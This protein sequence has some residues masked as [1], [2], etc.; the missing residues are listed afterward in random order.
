MVIEKRR[1]QNLIMLIE[2]YSINGN[3]IQYVLNNGWRREDDKE[4]VN[5]ARNPAEQGQK[6]VEEEGAAETSVNTDSQRRQ[7]DCQNDH[8]DCS[9]QSHFVRCS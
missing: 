3:K 4:S 8:D 2:F 1:R 5:D 7:Y 6:D 9:E